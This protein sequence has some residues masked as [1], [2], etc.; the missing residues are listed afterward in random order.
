[1][2]TS[3]DNISDKDLD[4][5]KEKYK[6][7]KGYVIRDERKE[8]SFGKPKE[9]FL[10]GSADRSIHENDIEF[11]FIWIKNNLWQYRYLNIHC[12]EKAAW[13]NPLA[14]LNELL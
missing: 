5:I 3:L 4:K 13:I 6:D 1:M 9:Y 12:S 7:H 10:F 14:L 2:I 8:L 11:T